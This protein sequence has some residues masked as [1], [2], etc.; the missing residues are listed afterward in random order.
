M[1]HTID[2]QGLQQMLEVSLG[3]VNPRNVQRRAQS[4]ELL[5]GKELKFLMKF[6]YGDDPPK[7][8]ASSCPGESSKW[9]EEPEL[10]AEE[11]AKL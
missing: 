1:A 4:E 10:T 2:E 7:R 6:T 9:E 3:P 11:R 8:K 5:T